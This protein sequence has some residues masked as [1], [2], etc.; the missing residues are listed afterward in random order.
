MVRS[1]SFPFCGVRCR[2]GAATADAA[3]A[4]DAISPPNVA[5]LEPKLGDADAAVDARAANVGRLPGPCVAAR[6]VAVEAFSGV[7]G[8][9]GG[10]EKSAEYCVSGCVAPF[11]CDA[12]AGVVVIP[13][14]EPGGVGH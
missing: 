5:R 1:A 9:R 6:E 7:G 10:G 12:R 4:T 2:A 3:S 8:G 11:S 13:A 14:W